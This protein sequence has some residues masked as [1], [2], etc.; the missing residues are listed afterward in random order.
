MQAF[1]ASDPDKPKPEAQTAL[2]PNLNE[3]DQ[4]LGTPVESL[5]NSR[6]DRATD[7]DRDDVSDWATKDKSAASE[8]DDEG[9]QYCIPTDP[10]WGRG[11]REMMWSGRFCFSQ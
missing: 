4:A 2:Q 7:P 8:I 11:F 1:P 10:S 3:S 5:V 6:S 9:P